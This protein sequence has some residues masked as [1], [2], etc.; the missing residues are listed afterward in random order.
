MASAFSA[1]TCASV[2]GRSALWV[3]VSGLEDMS[4]LDTVTASLSSSGQSALMQHQQVDALSEMVLERIKWQMQ[5]LVH[6]H[7]VTRM[8][9]TL[10]VD[11][12]LA[13]N[14]AQNSFAAV[15]G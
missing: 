4:P 8:E 15:E 12:E 14:Q 9:P 13:I 1:L 10:R 2:V 3:T 7:P 6:E 11:N 5:L